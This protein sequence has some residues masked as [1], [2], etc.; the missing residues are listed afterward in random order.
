MHGGKPGRGRM[1]TR[2]SFN[3]GAAAN[4]SSY[5]SRGKAGYAVLN[6][7]QQ[8]QQKKPEARGYPQQENTD[9]SSM[10]DSF[11]QMSMQQPQQQQQPAYK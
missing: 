3:N 2:G 10:M 4:K 7:Q 1:N 11:Q 9:M 5:V 8:K 6:S